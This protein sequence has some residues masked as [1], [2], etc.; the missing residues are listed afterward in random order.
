MRGF[1]GG[2]VVKN[3]PA[4]KEIEV[5]SLG[6]EDSLEEEMATHPSILTW[7]IPYIGDPSGL[8]SIVSQTVGQNGN[9]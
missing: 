7:R 5:Q 3:P 2:S 1:P 6:C 4:V 8:Q 9:N